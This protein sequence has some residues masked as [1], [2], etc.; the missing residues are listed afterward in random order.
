MTLCRKSLSLLLPT[1]IL[2]L[3]FV[4]SSTSACSVCFGAPDSQVAKG[5]SWSVVALLGIV[6]I[7]LTGIASFFVFLARRAREA[8]PLPAAQ[9]E[10]FNQ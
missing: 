3:C 4:P 7:V 5:A 1:V 8:G 9:T 10:A 6:M 2:I